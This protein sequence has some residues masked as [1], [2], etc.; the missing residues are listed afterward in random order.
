MG[1][2]N[3]YVSSGHSLHSI[4]LLSIFFMISPTIHF[5]NLAAIVTSSLIDL[6]FYSITPKSNFRLKELF[7][8]GDKRK[9]AS[10]TSVYSFPFFKISFATN[11]E[12]LNCESNP[13]LAED[14]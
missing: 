13:I 8:F 11:L 4:S 10:N 12:R 6:Y 9:A 2:S 3:E 7:S 1:S 5:L 14:K